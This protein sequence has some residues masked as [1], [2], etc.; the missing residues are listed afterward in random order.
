MHLLGLSRCDRQVVTTCPR[1]NAPCLPAAGDQRDFRKLT[2][3][4]AGHQAASAVSGR[5][6]AQG[7]P[8]S[9]PLAAQ[10]NQP[11]AH[12]TRHLEGRWTGLGQNRPMCGSTLMRL[13]AFTRAVKKASREEGEP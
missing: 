2:A 10:L 7:E 6:A 11:P 4:A 5:Q 13:S 3:G 1:P 8:A 12:K 9:Q